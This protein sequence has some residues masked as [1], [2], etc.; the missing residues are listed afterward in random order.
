MPQHDLVDPDHRFALPDD[1]SAEAETL[2]IETAKTIGMPRRE[3]SRAS[4]DSLPRVDMSQRAPG[5][6]SPRQTLILGPVLGEGG[7]GQVHLATQLDLGREVAVKSL[8]PADHSAASLVALLDEARVMGQLEHPNVIP[9]H[10]LGRDEAG[11]PL[12]VMKRVEG[13]T[14]SAYLD[15][16]EGARAGRRGSSAT[17]AGTWRCCS[18]SATPST[19]PTHAGSCIAT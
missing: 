9:V 4:T 15:E 19:T 2:I 16:R 7:M 11:R 12:L 8:K 1:L 10:L 18:R 3:R 13:V 6:P 5:G 14:W 17:C